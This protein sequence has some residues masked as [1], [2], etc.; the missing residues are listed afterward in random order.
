MDKKTLNE[1]VNY[2]KQSLIQSGLSVDFI[3]LFGSALTG[4]MHKDSDIDLIVVSS[5]FSDMDIF[6]RANVTMKPE[7]ETQRKYSIP[8]DILNLSP[9]E[10]EKTKSK[11][12]YQ[13]EIVA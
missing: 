1:L 8:L 12:Y 13:S 2:L 5:V 4:K 3:A 7:I 9:A 11:M 6:E 10:Y